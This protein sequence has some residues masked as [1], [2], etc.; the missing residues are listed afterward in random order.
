MKY[1]ANGSLAI[2]LQADNPGK[3][4]EANRLPAPRAPF[5]VI[6]GTYALGEA[7]IEPWSN[8]NAYVPPPAVGQCGWPSAAVSYRIRLLA[9]T[10]LEILTTVASRC[11]RG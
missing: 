3:D 10:S 8:P 2:D 9:S 5:L 11:R 1:N 6:L 7:V 4:K